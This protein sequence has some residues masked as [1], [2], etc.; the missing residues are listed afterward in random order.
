[1]AR[2]A[3]GLAV[4]LGASLVGAP[5]SSASSAPASS[6]SSPAP[7]PTIRPRVVATHPHDQDAFTQGLVVHGGE[8]LESTGRYGEDRRSERWTPRR[9]ASA[10]APSSRP[11]S[12]A[13]GVTV[14]G[15]VIYMLT[16]REHVCFVYSLDFLVQKRF[17]YD[18]EGWG[19]TED[20]NRLIMSDGT[21]TL[22][23]VDPAT[24]RVVRTLDVHEA[25]ADVTRLNEL[26]VVRGEIWAN[27]WQTNRIVRIAPASGEV[28]GELDLRA[29]D[30]GWSRDDP[31][32][33]L[34]GIAYDP[35][36]DKIYVT[37]KLW[38][39]LYEIAVPASPPSTP[40][41]GGETH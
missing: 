21:N 30:G 26:E 2:F 29:I 6:S 22:R 15:D 33:V 11:A 27:V 20:G 4:A 41:K 5:A 1:M 7:V 14:F 35:S 17:T 39:K 10:R 24:F 16:W 28:V 3:N 38:P 12:S 23:F 34:N 32:A 13:E 37:G 36:N 18:G 31:D 9:A 8:L 40:R 25:G 19:I